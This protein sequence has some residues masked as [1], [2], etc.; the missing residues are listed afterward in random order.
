[1]LG[2]MSLTREAMLYT[3][4]G[5]GRVEC[6][7][8]SR[9]CVI[10]PGKLGFCRTRENR[11]GK[12]YT[13][14]YG[15][16][17]SVSADPIEKKP[18]YHFM[19]GSLSY[20][21]G[22][23]GCNFR[24][25]HCQNYTVSQMRHDEV[26]T[27]ELSPEDAVSRALETGCRSMA[28]TYN[29]PTIWFEYT[30]DTARLAHDS[31][32]AN[33]YVTNG[34]ITEEALKTI[35]PYLDALSFDIKAFSDDFYKNICHARLAPVLDTALL[36]KELGMHIEVVN[37]IIPTLNDSTDEIREFVEWIKDNLGA[38]T[39]LHFTRFYPYYKLNDLPQT[40]FNTL[41]EA[42]RIAKDAGMEYVYIGNVPDTEQNNTYCPSCGREL[43]KRYGF[44]VVE[45]RITPDGKCPECGTRIKVKE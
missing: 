44:H 5:D 17:S 13:L 2:V 3:G 16:V 15:L 34:Y 36:G 30:Y 20:S 27:F 9:R 6:G 24:C 19:P 29:E 32:L 18:L 26:R 22:T 4:V 37:L 25:L 28:F 38:D 21:L 14:I 43:I 10:S 41:E 39:P 7:V 31:G 42:Y 35:A 45:N 23:V 1:M 8:C 11:D 12:L 33:V 40:P